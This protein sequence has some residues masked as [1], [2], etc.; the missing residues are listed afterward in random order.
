M[1]INMKRYIKDGQIKTRNQI[2][3]K[4]QR[5]IKDKDGNDKVVGTNTFNPTEEMILADG[6]LEYVT[7]EP[8]EEEILQNTKR[9]IIRD[10]EAYDKSDA[11]NEFTVAEQGIWLDKATR[12]GLLLRFQAEKAQGI[13]ETILWHNGQQF[14]LRVDQAIQMLYAIELYASACYD[15]TQRHIANINAMTDEDKLQEY[16]YTLGYPSKLSF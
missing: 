3:I 9:Q 5:I 14:P 2:V 4:S 12:S 8:T 7:P 15:N 6:W 11:V 13:E 1:M 16:D 10:I